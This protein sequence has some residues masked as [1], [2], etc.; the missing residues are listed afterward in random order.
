M[1]P[2]N[3]APPPQTR[4]PF[5]TWTSTDQNSAIKPQ[6]T[7]NIQTVTPNEILNKNI[8][9]VEPARSAPVIQKRSIHSS[10]LNTYS[11]SQGNF[12]VS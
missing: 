1:F 5:V 8:V 12:P 7:S 11:I 4:N 2:H 6:M 10:K 3:T 9:K